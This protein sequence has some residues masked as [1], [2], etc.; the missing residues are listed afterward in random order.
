MILH[1]NH[2]RP[3]HSRLAGDVVA[4]LLSLLEDGRIDPNTLRHLNVHLD[5]IQYK[6]NFREPVTLRKAVR[7][8]AVLPMV[9]I[10]LDLRQICQDTMRDMIA[11]VL[12]TASPEASDAGRVALEPFGPLRSSVIWNFNRLYWQHLPAWERVS[13]KGYETA[14]PGGA[15]D[16]QSPTAMQ[17]SAQ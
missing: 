11:G 3:G 16:G 17:D 6:T 12:R 9:E 10:A 7:N 14:L 15:S 2:V 5:W 1:V 8:E 4:T 13:G